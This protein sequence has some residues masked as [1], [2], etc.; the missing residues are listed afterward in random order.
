MLTYRGLKEP[1]PVPNNAVWSQNSVPFTFQYTKCFAN[2]FDFLHVM[3]DHNH[4]IH[5][6][7][8]S[9]KTWYTQ[10]WPMQ[11]F[12]FLFALFEINT[13]LAFCFLCVV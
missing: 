6:C 4:L 13:Y 9:E 1:N 11:F 3:D 12:S 5:A 7:P 2:H 10:R 8:A